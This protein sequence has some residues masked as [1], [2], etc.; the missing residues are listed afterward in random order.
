MIDYEKAWN[1]LRI[2]LRELQKAS[3]YGSGGAAATM[4]KL[5]DTI[6]DE[7]KKGI[8]TKEVKHG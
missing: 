2:V 1:D 4:N 7:Q 8:T 6:E 3:P 5:M